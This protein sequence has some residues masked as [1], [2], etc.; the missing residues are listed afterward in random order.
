MEIKVAMFNQSVVRASRICP[1]ME[2][3]ESIKF[4]VM[5]EFFQMVRERKRISGYCDLLVLAAGPLRDL[6]RS[7]LQQW[8]LLAQPLLWKQN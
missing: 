5:L 2:I 8:Y 1:L 6:S 7:P 4:H 3:F